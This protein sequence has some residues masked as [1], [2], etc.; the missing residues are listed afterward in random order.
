MERRQF[1]Q[2]FALSLALGTVTGSPLLAAND[3]WKDDFA[4]ALKQKPWLIGYKGVNSNFEKVSL[5]V[6]GTL[7]ERL[8]GTL[9]RNGAAQ[10]EVG[11]FRYHHWFDGDGMVQAFN[12]NQGQVTHEGRFVE[13]NKFKQESDVDAAVFQTFGTH[14]P[15]LRSARSADEVSVAN[16]SVI[17]HNG[18]LLAL[19]EGGSAYRLDTDS[20][21]TLGL[22]AWTDDTAG[23]PFSAHP[24]VDQDGTLWNFGYAPAFGALVVYRISPQGQLVDR[25][26]VP[27]PATPMVH[28]FLITENHLV[29]ILPPYNF[30]ASNGGSFLDSFEWQPEKGGRALIINKNDLS[31]QKIVEI[32]AFWVFHF[33]NGFEDSNGDICFDAPLY[34]SPDI[35]TSVFTEVM[36]GNEVASQG[37]ELMQCKLNPLTGA[38]EMNAVAEAI[39]SEFPRID[40]R[41]QGQ[42]HGFTTLMKGVEGEAYRGL[43][44]VLRVDHDNQS[45]E[46]YAF[47]ASEMAEEHVFVPDPASDKEGQGWLIG[48]SLDFER[49]TSSL[50]VFNAERLADGPVAVM[51]MDYVIPLGLHGNFYAS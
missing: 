22:K 1:L 41:R 9:F 12:F 29:L 2:S 15:Q 25:A 7:P 20:L 31:A 26:V 34:Q 48:T 36:R 3:R 32:P 45:T 11:D 16:I 43:N 51:E 33:A 10:H 19:W 8:N 17:K 40:Q 37:S 30:D 18:E 42:R 47:G 35:M 38:F 46:A 14:D 23:L 39:G 4:A 50:N 49:N 24:R 5:K 21:E 28:D 44:Q 6:K 27:M 13:T